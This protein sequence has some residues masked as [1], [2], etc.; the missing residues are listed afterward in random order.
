M[1]LTCICIVV[2]C[3]TC[4]VDWMRRCLCCVSAFA[5]C[6][7][8][9]GGQFHRQL[10]LSQ[11]LSKVPP[12]FYERLPTLSRKF[13]LC[14][15]PALLQR[16]PHA[17][18]QRSDHRPR[19]PGRVPCL[20]R[21]LS[22]EVVQFASWYPLGALAGKRTQ[23]SVSYPLPRL[24]G[25]S[26]V[27]PVAG[28]GHQVIIQAR[29]WPYKSSISSPREQKRAAIPPSES[30][31]PSLGGRKFGLRG[32]PTLPPRPLATP[33]TTARASR[34]VSPASVALSPP[35]LCKIG[36]PPQRR[37]RSEGFPAPG[38]DSAP[39]PLPFI[40]TWCEDERAAAG[41]V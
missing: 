38:A 32:A 13:G 16:S 3:K 8:F 30:T 9:P 14:D 37:R 18:P 34:G 4:R 31:P 2:E 27:D 36:A 19:V 28:N 11:I 23:R 6:F 24:T 15:A 22:S 10:L 1:N 35:E 25:A 26:N 20:P 41:L 21:S 5:V 33:P 12:K 17:P 40:N 39:P 7:S 29:K